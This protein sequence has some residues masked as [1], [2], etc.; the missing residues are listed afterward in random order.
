MVLFDTLTAKLF[1]CNFYPIEADCLADAIHI[2]K[3][4]KIIQIWQMEV[5]IFSNLVDWCHV[6]CLTCLKAD[7][8]MC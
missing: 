4:V 1:D 6:L 8:V 3:W 7:Y 2:L 5:D